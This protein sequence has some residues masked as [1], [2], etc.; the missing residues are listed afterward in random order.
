V[1]Q[2]DQDRA[3]ARQIVEKLPPDVRDGTISAAETVRAEG[4]RAP[5]DHWP[6]ALEALPHVT[7]AGP[8][9][10]E[11]PTP[12]ADL[13][14]LGTLGEGGMG[15][16]YLAR[17][18]SLRRDVAV[19]RSKLG[20][21]GGAVAA[22]LREAL[23]TGTLEHPNIVPVHALGRAGDGEP[24]I[25][26][27]RIEGVLWRTLIQEPDHP[28]WRGADAGTRLARHVEILMHVCNAL[29]YAHSRKV[30]HRDVKP[31][32]VMI[33]RYGEVYLLDW[34][35]ALDA[36][37][38]RGDACDDVVGSPAYMAPEMLR[39]SGGVTE[40]TD[41][42]LLGASLHEA[43]TGAPRHGTASCGEA[44]ARALESAPFAYDPAVPTE[45]G[46]IC[47]RA[48]A[49]EPG[50]RF[51]S[52]A[53]LRE[54]L[55]AYLSHRGSVELTGRALEQLAALEAVLATREADA[56]P[57]QRL[58]AHRLFGQC[59]FAFE[60]ALSIWRENDA[61]RRGLQRCLEA[62]IGYE[63]DGGRP[64][65]ADALLP[66]LP[67]P[68]PALA[69]RL[70][71]ERERA[72]HR[73]AA[74]RE[75]EE[76]RHQLDPAVSRRQRRIFWGVVVLCTGTVATV[77]N[78]LWI[79]RGTQVA[80]RFFAAFTVA[81]VVVAAAAGLAFRKV[82]L[83]TR[84]NRQLSATFLSLLCII[85]LNRVLGASTGISLGRIVAGDALVVLTVATNAAIFVH[86]RYGIL[87]GIV[88]VTAVA[89]AFLPELAPLLLLATLVLV[90]GV[91]LLTG[92]SA[93]GPDVSPRP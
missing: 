5:G 66:A 6:L 13:Q 59:R 21:T 11:A 17:Q 36:A 77:V 15:V 22:L 62:V 83:A 51:E 71:E 65:A 76:M 7:L 89:V 4:L 47:N 52:A 90:V 63:L 20:E 72:A 54:A 84:L 29:E 69:A 50:D 46:A 48:C 93:D 86:R 70:A 19:K 16:V 10:A 49:R 92:R 85:A 30:L 45:L 27:K 61:A 8:G 87:A 35:V 82:F 60:H 24:V 78:A 18:G 28:A 33:G 38:D 25:V 73:S 80:P 64:D 81:A 88:L 31:S 75:L 79:T 34:G 91:T 37:G 44:V 74:A 40:R 67:T 42:Y 43:L 57:G 2:R 39:G 23:F 56:G 26:M 68:N 58:E 3:R 12:G 53:A 41:V 9:T 14:L 1:T 32:N 55:E